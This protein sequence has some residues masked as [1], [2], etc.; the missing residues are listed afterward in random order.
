MLVTGHKGRTG[1][2]NGSKDEKYKKKK[3]NM[4]K[5]AHVCL[6][7]CLCLHHRYAT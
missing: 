6:M 5:C 1:G 2:N 3:G 4:V 7:W